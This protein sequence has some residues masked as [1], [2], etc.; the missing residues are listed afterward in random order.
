MISV[1][2]EKEID[3]RRKDLQ[4][5][6]E[7]REQQLKQ[8]VLFKGHAVLIVKLLCAYVFQG[9]NFA[10]KQQELNDRDRNSAM[11]RDR[12][13]NRLLLSNSSPVRPLLFV[14]IFY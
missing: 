8:E 6:Q 3:K 11:R 4:K 5:Q 9:E 7:L 1:D 14:Y 2:K 13:R 12:E 10:R